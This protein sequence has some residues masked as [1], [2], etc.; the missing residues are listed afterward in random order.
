MVLPFFILSGHQIDIGDE[1]KIEDVSGTI[2]NIDLR[3]GTQVK[4]FD[5]TMHYIPNR[6]I[7]VISNRSKGDMH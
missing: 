3:H 2:T 6:E 7:L 1:V 4:D 5:G